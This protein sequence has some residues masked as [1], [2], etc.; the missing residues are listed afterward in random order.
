MQQRQ[1]RVRIKLCTAFFDEHSWK[2]IHLRIQT[3]Y[4]AFTHCRITAAASSGKSWRSWA[5][6]T[7]LWRQEPCPLRFPAAPSRDP[8]YSVAPLLRFETRLADRSGILRFDFERPGKLTGAVFFILR[9]IGEGNGQAT[10]W[11]VAPWQ[12]AGVA[13]QT[14]F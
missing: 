13:E 10:N 11:I 6:A 3:A 5:A 2:T 12:G 4:L 7:L 1:R 8:F 9:V 14:N